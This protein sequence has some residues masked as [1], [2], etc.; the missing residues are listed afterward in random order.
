VPRFV[1]GNNKFCIVSTRRGENNGTKD[2]GLLFCG[3]GKCF[4]MIDFTLRCFRLVECQVAMREPNAEVP[5]LDDLI[6]EQQG[7]EVF[8]LPRAPIKVW[9]FWVSY[10]MADMADED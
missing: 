2:M 6:V 5:R 3:E 1:A 4:L 8:R 7:R 9:V 10:A